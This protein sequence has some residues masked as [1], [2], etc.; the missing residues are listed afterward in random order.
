MES[1][2]EYWISFDGGKTQELVYS[3]DNNST[4]K[5]VRDNYIIED[6]DLTVLTNW[7]K[8]VDRIDSLDKIIN[9]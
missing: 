1:Y 5:R 4:V 6:L 7:F 3:N 8:K 9:P 2:W